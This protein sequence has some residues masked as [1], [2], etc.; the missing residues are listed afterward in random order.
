MRSLF[1]W[2]LGS[3]AWLIGVTF[4]TTNPTAISIPALAQTNDTTSTLS[5]TSATKFSDVEPNYW[6]RSFIQALAE[7]NIITGFPDGTFKPEQPVKYAEFAAMIQKA[8][9]QNQV[10]Q[11]SQ[12]KFID[13]PP[14][15]WAAAAIEEAY[16]TGFLRGATEDM[17]L[18]NQPIT[19]VQAIVALANGLD[20]NLSGSA[21]SI[22]KEYYTDFGVIPAYAI[23]DVAAATQANIVVNYP[24]VKVFE[25][26]IPL[27]RAAVAAHLYQALV[28]LEQV[29]PLA[30]NVEATKYIVGRGGNV[31]PDP[32]GLDNNPTPSTRTAANAGNTPVDSNEASAATNTGT[33]TTANAGNTPVSSSEASAATNNKNIVAVAASNNSFSTLTV[34]LKKAGLA[35]FLQKQGPFTVFAPTNKAFATLPQSTLDKLLQPENRDTL[36]RI[37]MYHLVS[38]ELTAS[39]LTSGE[40]KTIEGNTINVKVVPANNQVEVNEANVI[41]PNIQASNG[42]I[43]AVDQVLLPPEINL[44]QL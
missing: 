42:V 44:E 35:E 39:K 13:V 7:R 8:F 31:S 6:A 43:H 32:V 29:Q 2:S 36:T 14:D 18:P 24:N 1:Q 5:P 37:L 4:S 25:S 23:D 20:L 10:R 16:E 41:Q 9:N 21:L 33:Q 3:F 34:A 22:L 26:Q 17:F 15:F 27:T 28:Q 19:K 40:V 12:S 30:S 11:Y 38:D